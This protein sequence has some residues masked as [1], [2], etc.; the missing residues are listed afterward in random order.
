M[1][2]HYRF[3]LILLL[4]LT[5]KSFSQ[6]FTEFKLSENDDLNIKLYK[7]VK[8]VIVKTGFQNNEFSERNFYYFDEQGLPTEI[9]KYGLGVNYIQRNLR[10]EGIHYKFHKGKLVSRLNEMTNGLDGEIYQYDTNMNLIS[11]KHYMGNIL[12]KEIVQKF[13]QKKRLIEKI[14]Y[15]FG[16]FREYDEVSQKN[17]NS[18]LYEKIEYEYDINNN[19]VVESKKSYRENFILKKILKYDSS[20]N[21]VEEGQCLINKNNPKCKYHAIE[22]FEYDSK[23]HLIKNFQLAQFLPH[24]TTQYFKFDGKGNNT[25]IIGEYIYPDKKVVIG[26]H[27]IQKFDVFGNMIEKMDIIDGSEMYNGSTGYDIYKSEIWEFDNKGNLTL[28]A[29]MTE[30]DVPIKAITNKYE[31]DS[32]G[33]WIKRITQKGKNF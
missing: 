20:N 13:D 1:A 8:S 9:V 31:Y 27:F 33:N 19:L 16:A 26:Y 15:L 28:N 23:K 18:F 21:I 12:V 25:E 22:G 30:K 4:I 11:E 10:D 5:S 17:K 6:E 32:N 3:F 29:Y 7:K 2:F 14:D 24:N